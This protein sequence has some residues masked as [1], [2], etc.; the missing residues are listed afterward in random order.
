MEKYFLK[1]VVKFCRD[2]FTEF[3]GGRVCCWTCM[4]KRSIQLRVCQKDL[5][6]VEQKSEQTVRE[7][8]GGRG[9]EKVARKWS[10]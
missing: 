9:P 4:P 8:S 6:P 10:L 2:F 5:C 3:P 7:R 1:H